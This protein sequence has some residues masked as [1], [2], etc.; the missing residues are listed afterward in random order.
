MKSALT[1]GTVCVMSLLCACQRREPLPVMRAVPPFTLTS[2][3]G[4]PF[5]SEELAGKIWIA[6]FIYTTCPGPCPRMSS[7]MRRL[8][9]LTRAELVSI[10]INPG[11][12]TPE[13]LTAYAKRY[14]ADTA[15]WHFLTGK[16]EVI[17]KLKREAF[18]LGDV[19]GQLEHS[20]RFVLID[21]KGQVRAYYATM[22]GD[23]VQRIA[24]DVKSLME[25]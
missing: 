13:V 17:H 14:S 4:T 16:R 23:A 20:T 11:V 15:R 22:E 10:T 1:L 8:Q 18:K 25:E 24:D 2:Q 9:E 7:Q 6:D 5:G 19:T 12:D 3:S 21:R